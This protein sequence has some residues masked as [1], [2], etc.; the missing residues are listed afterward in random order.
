MDL[1]RTPL[2]G[3][4]AD[5]YEI[6]REAGRG[7]MAVV[8]LAW[9]LRHDRP[10]ALKLLRPEMSIALGGERFLREIQITAHLSH[11]HV[12][13]VLDSG[14]L[15]LPD[16]GALP[17]Y[18]MPFVDGPTL[19]ERLASEP[20]L[21]VD[22]A[23]RL[24]AEV[25]DALHYAHGHG[26]IHRDIKPA[27]ILLHEG[28]A[29]VAD[30]GVAR[31]RDEGSTIVTTVGMAIGTMHYMSPE[32]FAADPQ[33]DGRSDVYG[34][35][36]V[37]FE[38]L[39]GEP[40]FTGATPQAVCARHQAE[41]PRDL[42]QIRADVTA[43][44][45]KVVARSL[46]KAPADRFA[47]AAD[48]RDALSR[49]R[50]TTGRSV[51][52]PRRAPLVALVLLATAAV[53][54]T[55]VAWWQRPRAT[56]GSGDPVPPTRILVTN[57]KVRGSDSLRLVAD[58]LTESLTDRLQAVPD[59]AVTAYAMVAPYREEPPD[60]LR[61]HFPVDRVVEG[62]LSQHGDSTTVTVRLVDQATNQQLHTKSWTVASATASGA[63]VDAL[64]GFVRQTLWS[65]RQR[66]SRRQQV[67]DDSAWALVEQAG[68]LRSQAD[69]AV[70]WRADRQG[71]RMLDQ[72][73][74]LLLVA[75]QRDGAS[76][77]IPL[78]IAR[79]ADLRAYLAEYIPQ[80][81]DGGSDI[82]PDPA[83]AR[84]AALASVNLLLREHPRNA[85][86]LELRGE[87]RLGL[88]R[89]K[90]ADSALTAAIADLELA[91]TLDPQAVRSSRE[92]SRAYLM[93]GRY[94]E[95]MVAIEQ[96]TRVDPYQVNRKEL[97]RGHFEIA[98]LLGDFAK[99][100]SDCRTGLREFP[101]DERFSDCEVESWGRSRS[102]R[103][104][105]TR[106]L[107]ITDSLARAANDPLFTAHRSLWASAI[108]ARAGLGDSADRVAARVLG[109]LRGKNL[110]TALLVE[111]A[112]LRLLRGQPDSA[113]EL[114]AGATRLNPGEIPYLQSAPW[115]KTLRQDPR[116]GAALGGVSPREVT[117]RP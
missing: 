100:D 48:F 111:A 27:N 74:S 5:R 33:I 63:L 7:G 39:A 56:V 58:A 60:T 109:P 99:S 32:Q 41:R 75:R 72:A 102:D 91:T 77:L 18:V 52:A 26:V 6:R 96:A 87:I 81:F 97:L 55:A 11:P 8:Y 29:L 49:L 22:E 101:G 64:S 16:G 73:D 28:H 107:A 62:T 67:G 112:N 65:D 114:I 106:A 12:L 21:P 24:A 42:R 34:L 38:M 86:A 90:G 69:R 15:E 83:V 14:L 17:F 1:Q 46:A 61:R 108:L 20:R 47:S 85:E 40:P 80:R 89:V 9:D 3:T 66:A 4:I 59:L 93:A 103:A 45:Q 43:A 117:A 82:L 88:F 104:S 36:C 94:P 44:I 76:I 70:T 13:A 79:T 31:I 57:F 68:A 51:P 105:A 84:A 113:L 35:G 2:T 19:A 54:I 25:A 116:F 92:L 10:V 110:P 78:E 50:N 98:L 115:F 71:F 23:L 53:L 95:S 30:F 37:L